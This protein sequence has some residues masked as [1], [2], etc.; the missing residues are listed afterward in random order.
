MLKHGITAIVDLALE[1]P[2]PAVPR[3]MNYCRLVISDDGENEH[4][5]VM[6]AIH[7]TAILLT[8]GHVT[9]VCCNAGLNRSV[10]I[11]A[12]ALAYSLKNTPEHF[13]QI[14]SQSKSIDVNPA[15]WNQVVSVFM[16]LR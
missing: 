3:V 11:A 2:V 6:A 1:E 15:L 9:A 8:G 5:N 16:E 13:L 10:C 14:I 4:S 7:V 12:A